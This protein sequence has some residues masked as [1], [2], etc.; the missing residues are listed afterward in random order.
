MMK[1]TQFVPR[2]LAVSSSPI[3][4]TGETGSTLMVQFFRSREWR[5]VFCWASV[6]LPIFQA[7]QSSNILSSV[8]E[9]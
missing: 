4:R 3:A 2:R 5:S 9:G 6:L 8:L 1:E 7:S